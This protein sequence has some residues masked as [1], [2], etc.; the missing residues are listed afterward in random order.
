[1]KTLPIADTAW[2]PTVTT[3]QN[4]DGA[5]ES[6]M[7]TIFGVVAARLGYVKARLDDKSAIAGDNVMTGDNEFVTDFAGGKGFKVSGDDN[8]LFTVGVVLSQFLTVA[9]TVVV[10]GATLGLSAAT[11]LAIAGTIQLMSAAQ[12]TLADAPATITKTLVTVPQITASR[13][14]TLPAVGGSTGRL[15]FF[16]RPRSAD[17]FTVQLIRP[18]DSASLGTLAVSKPGWMLAAIVGGDWKAVFWGTD[19]TGVMTEV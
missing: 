7:D 10:N 15:C 16:R 11:D 3:I 2:T 8:A 14:Y 13:V 1:M 18:S 12:E 4:G 6:I 9:G 19:W 17:A 5:S